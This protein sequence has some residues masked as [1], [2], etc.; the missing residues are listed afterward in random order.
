MKRAHK[1]ES[2]DEILDI[3][4]KETV[5]QNPKEVLFTQTGA[6]YLKKKKLSLPVFILLL[7]ETVEIFFQ[8]V[9]KKLLH[10][11][12][13]L[14]LSMDPRGMRSYVPTKPEHKKMFIELFIIAKKSPDA[15][16]Q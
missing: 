15:H 13:F 1:K 9:K 8:R 7:Q 16:E 3:S 11:P 10:D 5:N 14:L 6:G 2:H 4:H 12:A